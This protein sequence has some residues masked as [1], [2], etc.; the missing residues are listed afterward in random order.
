[1]APGSLEIFF[2]GDFQDKKETVICLKQLS[3]HLETEAGL[4]QSFPVLQFYDNPLKTANYLSGK[5]R[6]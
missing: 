6:K 4:Y 2:P 3:P 1:M 5:K